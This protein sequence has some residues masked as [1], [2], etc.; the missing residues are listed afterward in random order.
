MA[1]L[2]EATSVIIR[3]QAIHSRY[4]SGWLAF[5]QNAP[6][7][8]LCSDNELARVGFMTPDDCRS[9]VG[10]LESIGISFLRDGQSQDIVVADQMRGLTVPCDWADFGR[11]EMNP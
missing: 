3:V 1:V 4:P 7:N 5:V 2:V 8:T 10:S 9:F 6:N 11:I